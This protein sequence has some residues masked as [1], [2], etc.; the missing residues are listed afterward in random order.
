MVLSLSISAAIIW[1][2]LF[3]GKAVI[4][5]HFGHYGTLVLILSLVPSIE[6]L[7]VS[8]RSHL[9]TCE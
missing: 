7:H 4:A 2:K 6:L 8:I 3:T 5:N 9:H 1:L